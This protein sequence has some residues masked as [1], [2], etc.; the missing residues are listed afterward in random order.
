MNG[1]SVVGIPQGY[2][3]VTLSQYLLFKL[4]CHE[5][6]PTEF[7]QLF[8][9]IIKKTSQDFMAIRPY[10]KLGDRKCDGLFFS[11]G[12]VFQV[13]SPDELTQANLIAK[14]NAD[15]DGALAHWKNEMKQWTFVYNVRRGLPPDIPRL[16]MAKRQKHRGVAIDHLDNEDLWEMIRQIG[17]QK[18][19]EILGAPIGYELLSLTASSADADVRHAIK[20]GCFVIIHDTM[21]PINPMSVTDALLPYKPFGGMLYINPI[22]GE[23]PWDEAAAYQ[24]DLVL[25]AIDRSRGVLPRFAVF[26][27]SQIALCI[28]LGFV[29]SDRL[30]VMCF[31]FDRDRKTWKWLKKAN[32]VDTNIRLSGIPPKIIEDRREAIIRVSLSAQ[33]SRSATSKVV[34]GKPIEIDLSI[35]DP[36]VMWLKSCDQLLALGQRFREVLKFIRSKMPN[37]PRI[38]LFY[39]GPTGG[40]IVVGQQINP[41]MNPPVELYEYSTQSTP[42]HRHALTLK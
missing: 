6:S 16:L 10:G 1:N 4:R 7:Q 20:K 13:Y 21:T 39:A 30:E 33:L 35:D 28:H 22:P 38:H 18:R 12:R 19:A 14:I 8:E 23:L 11:R 26:S 9:K 31:Q 37:C 5:C 25:T 29:L 40:A 41:R 42:Q 2:D 17:A 32:D 34:K 15:F 36:D 27:L 3:A 24:R